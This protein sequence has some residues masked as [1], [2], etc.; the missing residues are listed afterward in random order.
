MV[1]PPLT[2]LTVSTSV[3][4]FP[5]LS[6]SAWIVIGTATFILVPFALFSTE[7]EALVINV[8]RTWAQSPTLPVLLAALL[9]TDVV[10]PIPSSLLATA[11]GASLGLLH[12]S[13][14]T[15]VGLTVGSALGYGIGAG[16][17][18]RWL[19]PK[20]SSDARDRKKLSKAT[21]GAV[22]A[23]RGVPVLAEA[24]TLLAGAHRLP[25]LP[26]MAVSAAANV[27]VA[28]AYAYVGAVAAD[29]NSFL[30]AFGGSLGLPAIA[31]MIRSV[32]V[33]RSRRSGD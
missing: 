28:L 5:A 9:A 19:R 4:R 8:V 2:S 27:G 22:A 6:R 23:T 25:F 11:A 17:F 1:R 24:V 20:H 16:A 14:A 3:T 15:W 29:V 26:F 7:A 30:V 18:A 31:L 13:I 10:A 32:V 21:F 33:R 12:G